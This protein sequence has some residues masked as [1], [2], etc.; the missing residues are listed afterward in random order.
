MYPGLKLASRL[1]LPAC[2][3]ADV[4]PSEEI[5]CGAFP[6]N[7]SSLKRPSPA[8]ISLRAMLSPASAEGEKKR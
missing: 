7:L 1:S 8:R 4:E 6:P 3:G 5:E 2:G